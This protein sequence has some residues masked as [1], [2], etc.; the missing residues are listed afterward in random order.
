L[1]ERQVLEALLVPSANNAADLLAEWDAGTIGRFVARINDEARRL[2]LNGTH[3]SDASGIQSSTISTATDQVRLAEHALSLPVFAD[4]V[5][6]REVVM[7]MA[8]RMSN[9]NTLLGLPGVVGVKTGSTPAAGGNV[10]FAARRRVH[11][12][13]VTVVGAVLGQRVG[14]QPL[15]A[16]AGALDSAQGLL[17]AVESEVRAQTVVGAGTVLGHLQASWGSGAQVYAGGPVN[18]LLAPGSM[19]DA[20]LE[21]LRSYGWSA[22]TQVGRLLIR[23]GTEQVGV[24]LLLSR[25]L[26]DPSV[27]WRLRR[28]W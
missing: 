4:I 10:V 7:P 12:S 6:R 21:P 18:L 11:G 20:V 9:Y 16:L 23:T 22:G 2:G 25:S 27:T 26:Q 15:R 8:G 17:R 1:T 5:S 14:D 28:G 19:P 24:P 3:Y 13:S